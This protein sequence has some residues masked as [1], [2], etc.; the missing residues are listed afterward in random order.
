VNKNLF[1]T[2]KFLGFEGLR[3]E[4]CRASPRG[5]K[6]C[7]NSWGNEGLNR[8]GLGFG[9]S[10]QWLGFNQTNTKIDQ[11]LGIKIPWI[12]IQGF[13]HVLGETLVIWDH[14]LRAHSEL[15]LFC[16]VRLRGEGE[17]GIA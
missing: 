15:C 6:L 10:I 8:W 3:T 17:H 4:T 7:R 2:L 12:T 13:R 1:G 5:S 11:W 9:C 14:D 16:E